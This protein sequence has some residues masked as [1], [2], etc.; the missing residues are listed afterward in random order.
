[1]NPDLR[2]IFDNN[3]LISAFLFKGSTPRRAFD[4]AL[5]LGTIIHSE[6]TLNELWEVLVR[7]KFDRFLSIEDRVKLLHAFEQISEHCSVSTVVTLCRDPKDDKFLSLALSASA[8][9]ITSGD[10]DLLVLSDVFSVPIYTPAQFI[11]VNS[12]I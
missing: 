12:K 4:L 9:S 10:K 3:V 6:E 2:F 1:M 11:E 5:S 8:E 7:P